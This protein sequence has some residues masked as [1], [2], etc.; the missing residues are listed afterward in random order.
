MRF[1]PLTIVSILPSISKGFKLNHDSVV[2]KVD[3][4]KH[5]YAPE[6]QGRGCHGSERLI[7]SLGVIL[8]SADKRG[9]C[10]ITWLTFIKISSKEFANFIV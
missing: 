1:Q 3:P 5:F 10:L 8:I 2:S 6:L 7:T 4:T 9:T